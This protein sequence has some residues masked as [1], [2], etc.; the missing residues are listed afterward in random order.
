MVPYSYTSVQRS[1]VHGPLFLYLYRG[2]R[3]MVPYSYTCTEEYGTW[4]P[5]PIPV[6]RSMV[7]GPLFL[8]LYRGVWYMVPYSYFC[9]EE[10]GTWYPIPIPVQRSMVHGPLFLYL[11]RGVWYMVPYSHTCTEEYGTW[12]HIPIPVQRSMV[13]GSPIL[14]YVTARFATRPASKRA[15]GFET[16]RPASKPADRI[17]TVSSTPARFEA[18]QIFGKRVSTR[19]VAGRAKSSVD[20]TTGR[21]FAPCRKTLCYVVLEFFLSAIFHCYI[22]LAHKI[23]SQNR[24][25]REHTCKRGVVVRMR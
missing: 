9:T 17:T 5:I 25:E 20:N 12:S 8:Y 19:F 11:Y 13:H 24:R 16:G 3:Y 2:V 14:I 22:R 1:M 18:G 15:T 6:Q 7:H 23:H 21:S 10:Y 4:S